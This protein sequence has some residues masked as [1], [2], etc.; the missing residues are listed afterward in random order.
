MEPKW[1]TK[2]L[3]QLEFG[4]GLTPRK[5]QGREGH[6]NGETLREAQRVPSFSLHV[7]EL[8]SNEDT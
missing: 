5:L 2:V 8:A 3:T 7:G 4:Y 6:L 1:G